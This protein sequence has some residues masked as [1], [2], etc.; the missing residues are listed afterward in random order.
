MKQ[1]R[2]RAS[3]SISPRRSKPPVA[4]ANEAHARENIEVKI[5]VLKEWL[6]SGPPNMDECEPHSMA[7][8]AHV[9]PK[10]QRADARI[11]YFPRTPRQFNLWDGGQ[12][13][14]AVQDQLPKI[15]VNANATLRRHSDLRQ[16]AI[17]L[18]RQL[19]SKVDF[20]SEPKG[21]ETI[22][23]LKRL[24]VSEEKKRLS[25]E[26][27]LIS[28]RREIKRLSGDNDRLVD[29]KDKNERFARDEIKKFQLRIASY[30]REIAELRAKA[31]VKGRTQSRKEE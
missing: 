2:Q 15:H 3:R 12:N 8:D 30:E 9:S 26:A 18:M 20:R 17:E 14:N 1:S 24:L 27:E 31:V 21:R 11:D 6:E 5:R 22:A 10:T 19:S 25:L 16:T 29:L 28:Q 13:C 7:Q 4:H 23:G